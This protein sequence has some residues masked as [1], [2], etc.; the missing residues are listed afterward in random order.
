LRLKQPILYSVTAGWRASSPQ[1]LA[2]P[3]RAAW[4]GLYLNKASIVDRAW[5]GR[6]CPVYQGKARTIRPETVREPVLTLLPSVAD[7]AVSHLLDGLKGYGGAHAALAHVGI[8]SEQLT[9]VITAAHQPDSTAQGERAQPIIEQIAALHAVAAA[10]TSRPR[11]Q[12]ARAF[13]TDWARV[14]RHVTTL[15]L[16]P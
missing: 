16:Q 14:R 10:S 6:L 13:N 12:T 1:A 15:S 5:L 3:R 2:S 7:E 4:F 8:K 9:A 11:E